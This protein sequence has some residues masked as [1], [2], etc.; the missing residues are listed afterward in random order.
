MNRGGNIGLS[1]WVTPS[2]DFHTAWSRIL[3]PPR[4]YMPLLS[5]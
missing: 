2:S 3:F 1:D 5:Y 4:D